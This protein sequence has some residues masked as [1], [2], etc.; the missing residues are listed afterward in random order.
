M[1]PAPAGPGLASARG[2]VGPSSRSAASTTCFSFASAAMKYDRPSSSE[3]WTRMLDCRSQ[4]GIVKAAAQTE[5][6]VCASTAFKPIARRSVLFPDM[7][8]PVTS[9][10]VPGGP[11][12][13]SLATRRSPAIS[14]W[15]SASAS[16]RS[17]AG[18]TRGTDQPGSSAR[19]TESVASASNVP[20]AST[21]ARTCA[22]DRL[23]QRSSAN[24]TWKS[25]SVSA[26]TG[27]CSSAAP[28]RSSDQPP[29]AARWRTRSG[30]DRRSASRP[31]CAGGEATTSRPRT[32]G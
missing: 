28:L 19:T 20:S 4:G 15:P 17:V 31:A 3:S 1:S 29:S 16:R 6:P 13:T 5:T 14:G 22:P 21:Q 2:A 24:S 12:R 11:R 30:A 27:K 9:S 18:S 25:Q 23:R 10:I 32:R 7:L 8:E 26:C